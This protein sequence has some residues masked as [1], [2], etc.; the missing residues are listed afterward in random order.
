M[1]YNIQT[2][3]LPKHTMLSALVFL[4]QIMKASHQAR[5]R[6]RC[7]VFFFWFHQQEW[8]VSKHGDLVWFIFSGIQAMS[9]DFTNK[10]D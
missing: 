7:M 10:Y 1:M 6:T 4:G 3:H 2:P 8:V 5:D 9:R